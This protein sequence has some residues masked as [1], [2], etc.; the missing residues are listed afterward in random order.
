MKLR[1]LILLG[2]ASFALTAI[3]K[4]PASFI[5]QYVPHE[6]IQLQGLSGTIWK[7]EADEVI[8]KKLT[9]NNVTWSFNPLESLTSFSLKTDI[10]IQDPELTAK[11][12]VG[13][14]IAQ[15]ISLDNT[16]FE[17]TGAF[18]SK[19]QKIAKLSG[20][21]KGNI[22]HFTLAKG[23]LPELDATYQWKQGVLTAPIRIQ[24][25]GDYA[26]SI[27]PSDNG[28]NA[29]ISSNDAPLVLSGT[30]NID[31]KWQ[32]STDIN[33]KPANAS[34]KGTMNILRMAIGKLEADGSAVIKYK[35]QLK[36]FY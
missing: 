21:I 12:L 20:D 31:D 34:A 35:G 24:P 26:I 19:M 9:L 29:K 16:Q 11:G 22:T 8:S 36:P 10:A 23:E 30:A 15:T 28:L 1:N 14:N 2:V 4:T 33:I 3:W 6:N 32:Y 18:I 5:Y 27:S 17:T 7:G 25:A 13:I